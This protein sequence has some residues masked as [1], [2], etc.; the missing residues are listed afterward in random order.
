VI[1]RIHR[2][3]V[4]ERRVRV[5]SSLISELLPAGAS[6]LDVGCG[7][8]SIIGLIG[9]RRRDLRVA[10]IEVAA[11]AEAAVEFAIFDGRHI[12]CADAGVDVVMLIDVLH[13]LRQPDDLLDEA[14][15]VAR[16]AILIKDHVRRSRLDVA[17][18]RLMDWVG[19]RPHGVPLTYTYLSADEWR[20]AFHR[21]GLEVLSWTSELQLYPWPACLLFDRSLHFVA[22]LVPRHGN[23][24]PPGRSSR[25]ETTECGAPSHRD[26]A[27]PGR[28]ERLSHENIATGLGP[29]GSW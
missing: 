2:T 13:H 25:F 6:V 1:G 17:T 3:L 7:D 22:K 21:N 8:G 26:G 18:L 20:S 23:I 10:G 19:N 4:F 11:R 9:Q 12:P 5:L 24:R 16:Q 14:R 27:P 28:E 29:S 15:R